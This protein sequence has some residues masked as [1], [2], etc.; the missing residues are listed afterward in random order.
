VTRESRQHCWWAFAYPRR[1][2]AC[3]SL[4]RDA[5]GPVTAAIPHADDADDDEEE[6]SGRTD[7][8]S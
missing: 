1:P 7:R 2:H 4:S 3:T 8:A 5:S 6:A